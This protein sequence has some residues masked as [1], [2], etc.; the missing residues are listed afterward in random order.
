MPQKQQLLVIYPQEILEINSDTVKLMCH[1]LEKWKKG[2]VPKGTFGA[3][4]RKH[5]RWS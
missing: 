5:K 2:E 4:P 1:Y 3:I